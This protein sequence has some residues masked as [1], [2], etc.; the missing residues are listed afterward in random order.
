[1]L[2][3]ATAAM[4]MMTAIATWLPEP[5]DLL[6]GPGWDG[7]LTEYSGAPAGSDGDPGATSLMMFLL[8]AA[9]RR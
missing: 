6:L 8:G 4:A 9:T 2:H 7:E 1:M 3:K 5:V